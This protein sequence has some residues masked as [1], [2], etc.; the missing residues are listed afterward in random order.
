MLIAFSLF[1][2]AAPALA[3]DAPSYVGSGQCADCH[4]DEV[5]AWNGSHHQLAWTLPSPETVVADFDGTSFSGSGM[6]VAFSQD[7]GGYHAQVTETDGSMSTYDVHSVVGIAP[8]QQFLFETEPG[9]LQS[10]D[11]VWD[12]DAQEWYNLYPDQIL[13][14]NDGLH[15][16]G[17]YKNWNGR[18]AECHATGFEKNFD[19]PSQSYAS[20]QA[21]IGV[22]CEACHG[23]GSDH[24]A[25][26]TSQ[27]PME[28]DHATYGLT[29]VPDA[30]GEAWGQQCAGCHSRREAYGDGNPVP[31]TP[32][33]D[34]YRLSLLT[35]NLY[36]ADGQIQDEVY[37]YGSF[38]QSKMYA[39]GVTCT[40]C[41]D[42][43]SAQLVAEGNAVCTQCHSPAGNP[44]FP[45]LPLQEFDTPEHHFHEV[46]SA[47]A[48]CKNCHMAEQAYMGID[49]RADH[50]FRIPRPDLDAVTGAPDACTA[51]HQDRTPD[52][53]ADAI[54]GW[55]PQSTH[56]GFQF[57]TVFARARQNPAYA[58]SDLEVLAQD[59]EL[60]DLVRSTALYLMEGASDPATAE[61]MADLLTDDSPLV[62]SAAAPL[63][64]GASPQDSVLR[65]APLLNDPSQSVRFAAL[66]GMLGLPIAR[67]PRAMEADRARVMAEWQATLSTRL[68]F[69]ET[70]LVL[71][72]IALTSRDYPAALGA[73]RQVV[74]LD[75]QRTDAWS[76]VIR[77]SAALDG[78]EAGQA[79]VRDA[80]TI[81]P[82]DPM[83][84]DFA[85]QFG[86][87]TAPH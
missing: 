9:K 45:T 72:G 15:W 63:Q 75:P 70:H 37:V 30:D 66:R 52:W 8:L 64:R 29:M 87:S 17:P 19:F 34:A 12:A 54:A 31:G 59:T 39:E 36:H 57:G 2:G 20:V 77:L 28:A 50:S 42:P 81:L 14:P 86:V 61:A 82:D 58:R 53:A 6:S 25:W 71:G 16:T 26:A 49:L 24:I 40:N 41:H 10:F 62:R 60:A 76:M 80:L 65:L 35:P 56:R 55:Y 46:G 85:R 84:Q 18:C 21:E 13:P 43:H 78:E 67:L 51:C 48:E 4:I 69:P 79:A 68:D 32:Y 23:P 44:D 5:E 38:L 1:C 74:A 11:V 7:A 33:H 22:G 47:G 27:S 83:V 73:F 3:Q